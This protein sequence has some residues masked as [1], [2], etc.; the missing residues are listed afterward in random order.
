MTIVWIF[1][2]I[3]GTVLAKGFANAFRYWYAKTEKEGK[4]KWLGA[5]YHIA[6]LFMIGIPF[7]MGLLTL[8][9]FEFFIVFIGFVLMY[10][11]LMDTSFNIL[12][13]KRLHYIGFTDSIDLWLR[14]VFKLVDERTQEWRD[15]P[16][17]QKQKQNFRRYII[18]TIKFALFVVGYILIEKLV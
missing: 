17:K 12:T 6:E 1:L 2:I 14:Q 9:F 13:N 15:L 11:F 7:L 16:P 18:Y 10:S 5:A 8:S 4:K 3:L